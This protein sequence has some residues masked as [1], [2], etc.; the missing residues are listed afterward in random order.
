MRH[1]APQLPGLL[2]GH[3]DVPSEAHGVEQCV[4]RARTLEFE[5]VVTSDL[6]RARAPGAI[7]AAERKVEHHADARWRE[8]YFGEWEGA[9]PATLPPEPLGAFWDDPDRHPP[10]RGERW[11]ELC[12]R[13]EDA[14]RTLT[15]PTLVVTHAGAMRAALAALCGLD[16]R[17]CWAVDLPYAAVLSLRVWPGPQMSGQM[18]ALLP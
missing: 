16:A 14:L 7:I 12:G 1:G 4:R 17:Q 2:L 9:D 3:F 5:R 18:T 6:S 13:V 8:L 11:G 15:A 10:P